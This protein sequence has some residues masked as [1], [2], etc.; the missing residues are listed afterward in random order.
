MDFN[1]FS[2][3]NKTILITGASSGIGRAVAIAC[4]KMGARLVLTARDANR[5]EETRLLSQNGKEHIIVTA[6]LTD[7]NQIKDLADNLPC[8]DGFVGSAGVGKF[9]PISFLTDSL[10]KD[11]FAINC[12]SQMLLTKYLLKKKRLNNFSSLVYIASIAGN[13]NVSPANSI[14]GASKSALS[15]FVK[16]AALELASRGI[17]CN[18]ILPGRILTPLIENAQL[19][20]D[21]VKKDMEKYPLKRYGKPEEVAN[22]VLFL[23]SDASSWVTGTELIIDGGRSLV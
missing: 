3:D 21:D 8:L 12:F 20:D 4:S 16:Y 7:E 11:I 17:R 10:I 15:S 5:L 1:P 2:L 19:T 22:A 6:D 18:S 14:Y 13:T 23:L 9:I